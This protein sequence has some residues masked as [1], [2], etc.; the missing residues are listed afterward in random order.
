VNQDEQQLIQQAQAG[1]TAAFAMLIEMHGQFV[2][3][4]AL[5]ALNNTQ[6]AEDIA[7][8]T[9]IRAWQGLASFRG[10]AQLRTWLYR[11][12][13]NLC[14]N[15]LP[16]LKADFEAL[17]PTDAVLLPE[18]TRSVEVG[19]VMAEWREQIYMAVD[20]LPETYRLLISLRHTDGYSY[21]EIA[22][23]TQMPLGTV[24]TGLFRARR[25]LQEALAAYE[26]MVHG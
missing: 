22:E 13:T 15:R 19:M 20:E 6:E 23:I 12:T 3:N 5:R 17:D 4:L 24:K 2:Y 21:E 7:Q 26:G 11:I 9:F 25:Q 16:R 14:Y 18:Q 10:E 1:D 8:E